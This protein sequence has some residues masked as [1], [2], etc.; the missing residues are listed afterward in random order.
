MFKRTDYKVITER[1]NAPRMIHSGFKGVEYY[2]SKI[3]TELKKY[4]IIVIFATK[5][6]ENEIDTSFFELRFEF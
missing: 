6:Y 3:E 1:M 2:K 4:K 5:V